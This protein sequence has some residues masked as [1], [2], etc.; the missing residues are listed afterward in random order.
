MTRSQGE[1]A[2]VIDFEALKAS[3][4]SCSLGELCL[5]RGLDEADLKHL[6]ILLNNHKLLHQGD[7]L[8]RQGDNSHHIFTVRSGMV[9]TYTVATDGTEQ[10]LGFHL[11]GEL[12]G[13]DG[14]DNHSHGCTAVALDTTTVCDFPM[15]DLND[16]CMKIPSLQKHL[17]GLISDEFSKDHSM[18]LLLA[19]RSSEQ[20][21]ATF[22]HNIST[23][24]KAAGF[25]DSEFRLIMNRAEIGNYLG[26]AVETVS[27]ILTKLQM[28]KIIQVDARLVKILAHDALCDIAKL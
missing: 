13:L 15:Q 17:L 22:L 14:M 1:L 3:C 20:K 5:P 27:R 9:K 28:K 8:F 23:R 11:P 12:L 24:Y 7:I 18:L 2:Q 10:V 19:K 26:L 4:R 25:S 6:D 16:L 21:I